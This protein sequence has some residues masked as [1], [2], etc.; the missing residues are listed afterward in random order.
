M[1]AKYVAGTPEVA[2]FDFSR[3]NALSADKTQK[4][5]E[6]AAEYLWNLGQGNHGTIAVPIT[7]A[8]L[9]KKQKL[10]I[11]AAHLETVINDAAKTQV[12]LSK[13]SAA[14]ADA[15]AEFEQN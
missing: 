7:F 14:S 11:V 12:Y 3:V 13:Q 5:I 6:K 8:S 10:D 2:R 1:D 9:T 15:S 4:R